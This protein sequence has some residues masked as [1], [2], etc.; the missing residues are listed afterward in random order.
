MG[1]ARDVTDATFEQ[2]VLRSTLPVLIDLWAPWC[3]PCKAI[4]PIVEELA[5]EYEGRLKV[6]KLDVDGN[7]STLATYG[8]TSIPTLL[9]FKGGA[10]VEQIKGAVPKQRIVDT[11]QNVVE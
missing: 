2:E 11:I 3:G 4:A 5:G 7:G 8:V 10:L 9:L 6:M 1:K